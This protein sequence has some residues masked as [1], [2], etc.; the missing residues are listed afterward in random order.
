MYQKRPSSATSRACSRRCSGRCRST[1]TASS[2]R[3]R[4]REAGVGRG[5]DTAGNP[6]PGQSSQFE[7]FELILLLKLDK[8]LLVQ[9]FEAAVSQS[10]VSSLPLRA[11]PF[12]L[13]RA[14]QR[15]GRSGLTYRVMIASVPRMPEQ[16][17]QPHLS[18]E[19]TLR[20]RQGQ[21]GT[22]SVR[23]V[24][25]PDLSKI[26]RFGSVSYSFLRGG[27]GHPGL[28]RGRCRAGARVPGALKFCGRHCAG[29]RMQW[30]HKV[31]YTYSVF[32][33]LKHRLRTAFRSCLF[34][35]PPFDSPAYPPCP[36]VSILHV[37]MLFDKYI[38]HSFPGSVRRRQRQR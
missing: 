18:S 3:R 30:V 27:R 1:R 29:P 36:C 34:H 15:C 8:Q 19:P 9:R 22:G 11:A 32:L 12:G 38:T 17:A 26:H 5:D 24:S 37:K 2:S 20:S 33:V 28:L 31:A 7:L 4:R 35:A 23:F 10:T 14:M 16:R 25:V 13:R 21:E 6:H